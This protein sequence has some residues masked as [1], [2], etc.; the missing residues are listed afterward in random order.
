MRQMK[1]QFIMLGL[2]NSC[3]LSLSTGTVFA[4]YTHWKW[5]KGSFPRRGCV[6]SEVGKKPL[7]VTAEESIKGG[8]EEQVLV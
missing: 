7:Y 2:K 6:S 1:I 3:L 5:E 4:H 8:N